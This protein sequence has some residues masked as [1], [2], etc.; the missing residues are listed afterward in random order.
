MMFLLLLLGA[1]PFDPIG[2]P[3][4]LYLEAADLALALSKLEPALKACGAQGER[5]E[6]VQF[7]I[8]PD[9]VAS[10]L[11]WETPDGTGIG[12]W[13]IAIGAHRFPEHS[14]EPIDV[15]TIV[16]VREGRTFLSPQPVMVPRPAGPLMLFVLPGDDSSGRLN[17]ALHGSGKQ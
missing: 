8:S 7:S 13:S 6:S 2:A 12:C 10:G 4:P 14:D 16:Y 1:A 9:G 15:K 3:L 11:K 17:D 5:T